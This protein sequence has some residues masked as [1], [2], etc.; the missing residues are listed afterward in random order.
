MITLLV[1]LA[2]YKV[3]YAVATGKRYSEVDRLIL[4]AIDEGTAS[5]IGRIEETFHLP[6]R[7]VIEVLVSLLEE[8]WIHLK[9][10]VPDKFELTTGGREALKNETKLT[11]SGFRVIDRK[12]HIIM[13]RLTGGLIHRDDI[14][15]ESRYDLT[16]TG[17]W[18]HG[19]PLGTDYLDDTIDE[20]QVRPFLRPGKDNWVYRIEAGPPAVGSHWLPVDADLEAGTL[21][22]LPGQWRFRLEPLLL[23]FAQGCPKEKQTSWQ[24]WDKR[25]PRQSDSSTEE[26]AGW[27]S[28]AVYRGVH[29]DLLW[30]RLKA[31]TSTTGG[32]ALVVLRKI[33]D[34]AKEKGALGSIRFNN[35]P[36]SVNACI[37][38]IHAPTGSVAHIGSFSWL[39]DIASSENNTRKFCTIGIRHSGFVAQV[40]R[41]AAA[42][43]IGTGHSLATS[44]YRWRT[45]AGE[46]ERASGTSVFTQDDAD[47]CRV[48]LVRNQDHL[49]I[50][51]EFIH[52]DA[53]V[54]ILS[55]E[56]KAAER[57][58]LLRL[59]TKRT[60]VGQILYLRTASSPIE[61]CGD[62]V[63]QH[64]PDIG[65]NAIV[66][67]QST[68]IGNYGFLNADTLTLS[69]PGEA[70]VRI[71]GGTL[72][73][74]LW[75]SFYDGALIAK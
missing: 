17:N 27:F 47:C 38:L 4:Q 42:F 62:A 59:I 25:S 72:P 43:L 70:S 6:R 1:P 69:R 56:V 20:G 23:E 64:D 16:K 45:A 58:L 9:V 3:R 41:T 67:D 73:R 26:R 60:D 18:N 50:T 71:D 19:V 49:G 57:N 22:G 65:A 39:A 29:I 10:G 14:S 44:P 51:D 63:W 2:L 40:C 61:L 48:S 28:E 75:R 11:R 30:G 34:Q 15:I 12:A 21:T 52:K 24:F 35:G 5:T 74:A 32:A 31:G 7:M 37:L 36:T 53:R 8:D 33:D 68:V 66:S 13:E 54:L 55:P 46:L